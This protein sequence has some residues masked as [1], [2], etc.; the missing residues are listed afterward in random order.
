MMLQ[1]RPEHQHR[2]KMV[3]AIAAS[4]EM[5]LPLHSDR[6][7]VQQPL[8]ADAA[9][10]KQILGPLSQGSPEPGAQRQMEAHFGPLIQCFGNVAMKDPAKDVLPRLAAHLQIRRQSE[11]E[12]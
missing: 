7:R 4:A 10:V 9:W 3:Y 12:L 8:L 5:F 2:P 1:P 11:G 6:I